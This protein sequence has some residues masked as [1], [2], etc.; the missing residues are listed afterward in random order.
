MLEGE[1]LI[2]R[3]PTEEDENLIL[4]M[5]HEFKNNAEKTIPGSCSIE[6]FENY[7]DWLEKIEKYSNKELL[8]DGKVPSTQFIAVRKEDN[9]MIGFVNL[10]HEL[11]DYLFKFGGHIGASVRPSERRK[12]YATELIK[13][14]FEYCKELGIKDILITCK[15][16]NIASKTS[17]MKAGGK[18]ENIEIDHDGNNLERYWINLD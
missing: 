15:D 11:N 9:K 1:R 10:R 17:I 6:S 18:F 7:Q 13:I 5:V 3:V 12:G 14:C 16:W 2:L 8:S 4:E